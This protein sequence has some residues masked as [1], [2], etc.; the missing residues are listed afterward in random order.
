MTAA[1]AGIALPLWAMSA[2]MMLRSCLNQSCQE[3][4]KQTWLVLSYCRLWLAC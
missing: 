3:W 2:L 1:A 4:A